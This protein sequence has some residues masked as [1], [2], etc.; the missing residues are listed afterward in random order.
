MRKSLFAFVSVVC[1]MLLTACHPSSSSR[2]NA[3]QWSLVEGHIT[4]P[5]AEQVKADC[6]LPEYPRMQMQRS[7]WQNLN[8][9]WQYAVTEKGTAVSW[10]GDSLSQGRIL[11]PFAIESALSGVGR[12]ITEKEELWYRR[13]FTVPRTW[14]G[15]QVLLHFGAVDWQAAVYVNGR[16]AAEHTGGYT[17]F[18]VNITPYLNRKGGAEQVLEVRVYDPTDKGYQPRGKQVS[19]PRSI[20][21]TAVSGIWQTVWMEPVNK[22]NHITNL[23][24]EPDIDRQVLRVQVLTDRPWDQQCSVTITL[25]DEQQTVAQVSG[26]TDQTLLIPVRKMHL[27]SPEDPFLYNLTVVLKRGHEHL[28][29]V[30]SYAAMRKISRQKDANGIWRMQLNNSTYFQFGPL[31]QGWWPD[32]LYTAPTDEAL[33][34]DIQKTKDWGFNM[35]RKHV[36]VEPDRWYYHCDRLGML[37]WQDMPSGDLGN[38]WEPQVLGGGTDRERSPQSTANYY[39][40]WSE[41]I[42]M[43]RSHP[44]V[45]VWVPFNEAWGQFQTEQTVAW[46]EQYDPTRLVN[47]ASGGNHRPCGDMLDLHHY[48][49]PEMYLFDSDRVNVLGEYGGIGWPV[50]DHL[51]WNQRNW[52]YVRF[53]SSEEVTQEYVKYAE[54][55]AALVR[56]GFA[57]AVYTQT[58]DVEGEVNGL[59]T[60]DRKIMKLDEQQ[61]REANLSVR[62]AGSAEHNDL[63][64]DEQRFFST[65]EGKPTRLYTLANNNGM[66][67]QVTN[68]GARI[69]S[70]LVPDK[71]GNKQDV[72]LGFDN[73]HDYQA[74]PSDFGACIG[75]YANR[76]KNGELIIDGQTYQLPQNNFTHTLHGGPTGWQ[77]RVFDAEQIDERTLKLTV[78]SQDGDN[79]FP[80]QV[81]AGC[82]YTLT[83]D[84]SIRID[85]F[86]TTNAPT[87][88]NMTNHTY[89]NLTGDGRKD[90]LSHELQIAA[91]K[92]TPIDPTYIPTGEI[93]D[94]ATGSE[95]DFFSAPKAIGRDI[96][97][98]NE[99][100]RNGNGYDHNFILDPRQDVAL[101]ATLYSPETGITMDVL[102]DQPGMQ[103]YTGN[104]LDGTVKGK[105]G[106]VYEQRN[107]VC[108]ETQIYPDSPH[109]PEWPN[110]V[111]RPNEH[112]KTTTIFRFGVKQ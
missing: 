57:A 36:K 101:A 49:Q 18:S 99:Q 65:V 94:I 90:I 102:T 64:Q 87:V 5:W 86:G 14:R 19:N 28:D 55:L 29:K 67:V 40:E 8:G 17:P 91:H 106:E 82:T 109:H 71:Q 13:T 15:R 68:F 52:G 44:S 72:V 80:G 22:T 35:I 92:T 12:T 11:V 62:T 41:I 85:Y 97:S 111:L 25:M 1:M 45:V 110:C 70:I 10:N 23:I 42:D 4:T 69:V 32:G 7:E 74:I 43:L 53:T 37:V 3:G 63:L 48:P 105:R 79:G 95:F 24:L 100:L 84:N 59:M 39:H 98:N 56:K 2:S 9:L 46:T 58:T 61:L 104:F 26:G 93:T 76:I 96:K 66:Q 6:P 38:K 107:A 83:D 77:Y 73:I 60:Y 75:R 34:F 103:V 89:F 31:D 16:L 108:L 78:V 47:A 20:W 112:Y 30:T 54:Q 51:W 21:Y 27:W 81:K 88:I 50:H 33:A